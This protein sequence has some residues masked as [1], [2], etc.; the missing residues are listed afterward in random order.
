MAMLTM[1]ARKFLQKTGRNLGVNCPTSMGFDMAKV[2]CYNC[3]R[4]GHFSREC[5]SPKDSRRTAVAEPQRRSV[6]D[7]MIRVIKLRRN[8][9]TLHSW[10]SHPLPQIRL[11]TVRY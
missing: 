11:L 7:L 2:E 5:R 10:L 9:P 8:L 6:S 4:K 3:H 1:R